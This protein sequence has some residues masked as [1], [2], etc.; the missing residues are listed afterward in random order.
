[1]KKT[2]TFFKT[3]VLALGLCSS[4]AIAQNN[5]A[6]D[7]NG[8]DDYVSV[9]SGSWFNTGTSTAEV[10]IYARSY[11]NW[12]RIFDFGNGAGDNNVLFALSNGTSGNVTYEVYNGG[13]SGGTVSTPTTLPLNQWVHLAVVQNGTAVTIYKNGAVWTTGTTGIP[14]VVTRASNFIGRSN[15]GSDGYADAII[16]EFRIW[17]VAR[18]QTEIQNSMSCRLALPQ[19]GLP[20]FYKFDQGV[21]DDDNSAVTTL[22]DES[23]SGNPGTVINFN[24]NGAG[25]NAKLRSCLRS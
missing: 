11:N 4:A 23:G 8:G 6:L 24:L 20:L 25:F 19:T 15:W 9:P 13:S 17:D 2:I 22:T 10:W 7:F 16:D 21:A 3:F 5:N 12:S 1:M 18:T 14:T